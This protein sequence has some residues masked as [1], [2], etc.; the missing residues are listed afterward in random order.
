VGD[1]MKKRLACVFGVLRDM[2]SRAREDT[3]KAII[4]LASAVGLSLCVSSAATAQVSLDVSKITCWQ[5]VTY[6]IT[7]P[8]FIAI[9]VSGYYHGRIDDTTLDPP[10]LS[11]NATKMQ[12]YC[13][14]N[15]DAPFM[16]AAE[17]VLKQPN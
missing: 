15:P 12:E 11:A 16:Q 6:K 2:R 8:Q 7:N 17:T 9:W 5:F 10:A 4:T 1:Q 13:T 3:M 14:K